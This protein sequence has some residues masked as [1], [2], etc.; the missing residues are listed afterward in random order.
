MSILTEALPEHVIIR[1]MRYG[2]HTNFRSWLEID[3]LLFD[4]ARSPENDARI[5]AL[6][7]KILPPT[8]SDA[9]G[10]IFEFMYPAKKESRGTAMNK[11]NTPRAY[12]FHYDAEY[13]YADFM[14]FYNIDLTACD[15]HWHKFRALFN[16]LP[17]ESRIMDIMQ[18]RTVRLPDIKDKKTRGEYR[19][20]KDVYAL[21]DRRSTDERE[22]DFADGLW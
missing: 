22:G 15:M 12:S 21:P 5:T 20:L 1:G 16:A 7:Y 4:S 19:R 6:A 2:L 13:I 8:F 3:R 11:K 14:R 18:I 10:G 9:L 17:P